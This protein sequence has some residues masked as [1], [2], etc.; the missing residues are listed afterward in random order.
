MA[1]TYIRVNCTIQEFKM[2]NNISVL[3]S[4]DDM[5]TTV[6]TIDIETESDTSESIAQ[7][8]E[9]YL[10]TKYDVVQVHPL[11]EIKRKK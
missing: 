4:I 6:A 5:V 10:Q 7:A 11:E 8:M 2:A 1:A 3:N 9:T